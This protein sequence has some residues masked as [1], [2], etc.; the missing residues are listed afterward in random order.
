MG[1]AAALGEGADSDVDA[2]V[3]EDSDDVDGGRLGLT[4]WRGRTGLGAAVGSTIGC[5]VDMCSMVCERRRARDGA[6]EFDDADAGEERPVS[7]D[8]TVASRPPPVKPLDGGMP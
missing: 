2:L 8:P 3:C 7:E 5:S 4:N 1:G 6:V